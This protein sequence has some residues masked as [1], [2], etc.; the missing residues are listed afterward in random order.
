[1]DPDLKLLIDGDDGT[2]VKVM[3]FHQV[4]INACPVFAAMLKPDQYVE[5]TRLTQ[6]KQL[7]L[8]SS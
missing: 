3:V 1:M 2:Q 4:M 7:E 8:P 5:G 6:V